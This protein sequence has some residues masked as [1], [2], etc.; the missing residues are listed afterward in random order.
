MY[1]IKTRQATIKIYKS[2]KKKTYPQIK[3]IMNP[4]DYNQRLITIR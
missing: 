2:K 4:I 3:P 1:R